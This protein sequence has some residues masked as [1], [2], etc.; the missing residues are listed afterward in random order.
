MHIVRPGRRWEGISVAVLPSLIQRQMPISVTVFP[1]LIQR[2]M[3][4]SRSDVDVPLKSPSIAR[5]GCSGWVMYHQLV[6]ACATIQPN[7]K[8]SSNMSSSNT[9][10]DDHDIRAAA[11]SN[12]AA[13]SLF[14]RSL[15]RP[16]RPPRL[17]PGKHTLKLK[18]P[19]TNQQATVQH[20]LPRH[21]RNR[22]RGLLA[23]RSR[24]R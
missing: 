10:P 11:A 8:L 16:R 15:Y 22:R 24:L 7:C 23:S 21:L 6:S 19:V 4:I 14:P 12:W 13:G 5:R 20:R 18:A 3:P 2:Q 17:S 9:Q 1:S